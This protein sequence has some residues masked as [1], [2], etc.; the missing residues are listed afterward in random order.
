MD[1]K[2]VMEVE[3]YKGRREHWKGD[4]KKKKKQKEELWKKKVN[5]T[6]SYTNLVS[7]GA[8]V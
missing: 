1:G 2:D 4:G 8:L 3:V 5:S 6:T 7:L